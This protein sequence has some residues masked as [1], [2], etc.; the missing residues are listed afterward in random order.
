MSKGERVDHHYAR[1][2]FIGKYGVGKT[3]LMRRLLWM[4][5]QDVI[6]TESTDGIDISKCMINVENG[7]WRPRESKFICSLYVF[8]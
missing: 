4:K 1:V 5:K 8:I 3:S 6:Q 7:E 2:M